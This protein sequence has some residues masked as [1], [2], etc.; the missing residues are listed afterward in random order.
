MS[1]AEPSELSQA[2]RLLADHA[3]IARDALA[4]RT[5]ADQLDAILDRTARYAD[6]PSRDAMAVALGNAELGISE[7]LDRL[8][9]DHEQRITALETRRERAVGDCH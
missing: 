8:L 4:L 3:P 6:A 7:R 9:S 2:L 5:M 1:A